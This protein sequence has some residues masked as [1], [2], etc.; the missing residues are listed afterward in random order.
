M[1]AMLNPLTLL[2][3]AFA[4]LAGQAGSSSTAASQVP[5]SSVDASKA[6][7]ADAASSGP[8]KALVVGPSEDEVSCPQLFFQAK[9][10][11]T[12]QRQGLWQGH[13]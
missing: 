4:G 1:L 5:V 11:M 12:L 2:G 9:H 8:G 7:S 10:Q 3:S 6:S 13:Y